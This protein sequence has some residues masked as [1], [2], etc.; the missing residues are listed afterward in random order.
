MINII[1]FNWHEKE[2]GYTYIIVREDCPQ[3]FSQLFNMKWLTLTLLFVNACMQ[4]SLKKKNKKNQKL[5]LQGHRLTV[6]LLLS[7]LIPLHAC[8]PC[9]TTTVFLNQNNWVSGDRE[10]RKLAHNIPLITQHL[11]TKHVVMHLAR[12]AGMGQ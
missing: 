10:C 2:K 7:H 8:P 11:H 12:K 6:I 1:L 4:S 3:A 9:N 5:K